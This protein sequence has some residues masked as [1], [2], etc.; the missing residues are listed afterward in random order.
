M[1]CTVY[2]SGSVKTCPWLTVCPLRSVC[3]ERRSDDTQWSHCGSWPSSGKPLHN[4]NNTSKHQSFTETRWEGSLFEDFVTRLF[5]PHI[6]FKH[7]LECI[8]GECGLCPAITLEACQEGNLVI[9]RLDRSLDL[10]QC[11]CV[12]ISGCLKWCACVW[13]YCQDASR[14]Q[15]V[16]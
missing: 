11:S 4:I 8:F 13:D 7:I 1:C 10:F 5:Q 15:H 6:G 9:I 14:P 16:V 2:E 3:W 12:V